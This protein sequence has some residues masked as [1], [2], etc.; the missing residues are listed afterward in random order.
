MRDAVTESQA[1]A[2]PPRLSLLF[3]D[4]HRVWQDLVGPAERGDGRVF[5]PHDQVLEPGTDARLLVVIEGRGE[6]LVEASV[7]GSRRPS[8]RFSRG[9]F[10][11]LQPHA[12]TAIREAA[13]GDEID[14]PSL[15]R[16]EPRYELSWP[17]TFRTPA[18]LKP[19]YTR[20]ISADGMHIQM[21]ERVKRGHI[22][23]FALNTP[24]G[25]VLGFR[26]EVQWTSELIDRVGIRF[27]FQAGGEQQLLRQLILESA[28]SGPMVP[29]GTVLV[30]G[31]GGDAVVMEA[32]LHAHW[33]D[34]VARLTV[35]QALAEIRRSRP[36]VVLLPRGAHAGPLST[37][38][39]L[40]AELRPI[41]VLLFG[42]EEGLREEG[43]ALGASGII[44]VPADPDL[45][46]STVAAFLTQAVPSGEARP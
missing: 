45:V 15:G 40:D 3:T 24:Q 29:S 25:H 11:H 43:R 21:P 44:P 42:A 32:A 13:G 31:S 14:S 39:K 22:L 34:A 26:G 20:D 30:I 27:L 10:L 17:V 33:P 35:A 19:V 12:L 18:L 16:A 1:M 41:K 9:V 5:V 2:D 23:E 38:L 7:E 8:L 46:V 28:P 6:V 4:P 37:S 36:R